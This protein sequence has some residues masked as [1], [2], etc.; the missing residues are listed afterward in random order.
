MRP[1][2]VAWLD[3]FFAH[4]VSLLIAPTW[5]TCIGLAGLVTLMLMMRRARS[6]AIEPGVIASVILW[7]YLAAVVAGIVMPMLIDAVEQYVAH[8]R[9]RVRWAGMTSFWGYLAG[10]AAVAVVCRRAGLGIGRLGDVAAAPLG[11]ALVLSRLGC[12]LAGCD[13]GKVTSA[14]WA[15]RFPSGSPAWRSHVTGGLVPAERGAS[16]PV[17]PTQLYEAML[18]LVMIA[19]AVAVARLPSV[20][21]RP[22]ATFLAMASTYA[23]GRFGIEELRGDLG[24]GF[25]LGLSSGQVFSLALLA[26]IVAGVTWASRRARR[27]GPI[28]AAIAIA[29]LALS[30][31]LV[32]EAQPGATPGTPPPPSAP[33][34]IEPYPDVP[35]APPVAQPIAQ[36]MTTTATAPTMTPT[37]RRLFEIGA[38]FGIATPIN[39][40]RGQVAPLVGPSLSIGIGLARGAAVWIDLDSMGNDDASHGTVLASAGILGKVRRGVELGA[41]IGLG[42]TLVNFDEPAFRDVAGPTVRFEALVTYDVT[43]RWFVSVRPLSFDFLT[44]DNLGGPIFTWQVR[45]GLSYR[46]GPRRHRAA[47]ATVAP[48]P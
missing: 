29:I 15:M 45:G 41:R 9:V 5:F 30:A 1:H 22:G 27:S 33:A 47:P 25:T 8:G 40:R 13:Y 7:G 43:E 35:V 20:R 36:P 24:R 12:F 37:H 14:P 44:S 46:F 3:Q 16:L 18:G 38:L 39:R 31:P 48:T 11:V 34:P 21:A 2:V 10:G 17:H 4:E 23:I 19:V 42:T 6:H 32:A 26:V 28:A